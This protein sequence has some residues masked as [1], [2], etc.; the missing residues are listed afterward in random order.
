MTWTVFRDV[1]RSPI[2]PYSGNVDPGSK[3]RHLSE[4]N[5]LL[6]LRSH[7]YLLYLLFKM[8]QIFFA[9]RCTQTK[10]LETHLWQLL[11]YAVARTI[12]SFT[13]NSHNA[14]VLVIG[15]YSLYVC[16]NLYIYNLAHS[17]CPMNQSSISTVLI[18]THISRKSSLCGMYF[19]MQLTWH[20]HLQLTNLWDRWDLF[21][22]IR[23]G[24]KSMV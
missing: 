11:Y 6:L 15:E 22:K 23:S 10:V 3:S 21:R 5:S 2:G 16:T 19:L 7:A 24:T 12:V 20:V 9:Y 8:H 13:E 4:K 18:R 1:L 17:L 14:A